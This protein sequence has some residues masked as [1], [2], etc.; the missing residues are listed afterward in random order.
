MDIDILWQPV[1]STT[2]ALELFGERV[3]KF[4]L[5]YRKAIEGALLLG[6]KT[7]ICTIYNGNLDP[8]EAPLARI[9]LMMY[10]D[11]ILRF[12]FEKGLR[13]IDL[14][15]VCIE[16]ADYANPIEP[17]GPGGKKIARA[18]ARST[19]AFGGFADLS[20]VFTG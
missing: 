2:E 14:R 11:V 4:E 15:L 7:T 16:T 18:I 3:S 19:G 1:K 20:H 9:A 6:Y 5:A 13:V 8:D 10:N 17:S 12:A